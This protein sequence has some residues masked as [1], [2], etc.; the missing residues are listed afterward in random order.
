MS[1]P[2]P[3]RQG[4]TLANNIGAL[5]ALVAA[6]HMVDPEQKDLSLAT[7]R[8]SLDESLIRYKAELTALINLYGG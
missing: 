4:I 1:T 6:V 7:M 5:E 3:V 8:A 2:N